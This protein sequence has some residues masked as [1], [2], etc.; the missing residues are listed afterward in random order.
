MVLTTRL[1]LCKPIPI[2]VQNEI[3]TIDVHAKLRQ[4]IEQE[5]FSWAMAMSNLRRGS[6][7]KAFRC[8]NG[9]FDNI[10]RR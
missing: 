4:Y 5:S 8:T 1:H 2:S 6:S 10:N 9:A 7:R 3:F